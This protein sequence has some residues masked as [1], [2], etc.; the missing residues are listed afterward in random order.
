M[1]SSNL[2]SFWLLVIYLVQIG[3]LVSRPIYNRTRKDQADRAQQGSSLWAAPPRWL[4]V[5]TVAA[6]LIVT[7]ISLGNEDFQP[8]SGCQAPGYSAAYGEPQTQCT[9]LAEGFPVHYLSAV[10]D[11]S[12]SPGTSSPSPT[13]P[14]S[15]IPSSLSAPLSRT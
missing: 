15:P 14:C 11:L 12:L 2:I 3:L 6:G 4:L 7:L 13:W 8:M 10:P 9:T 5:T 1:R